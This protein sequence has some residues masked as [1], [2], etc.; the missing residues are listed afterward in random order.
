[1]RLRLL[2]LSCAAMTTTCA[3]AADFYL[4]NLGFSIDQGVS[5]TTKTDGPVTM[6][7][8]RA[9]VVAEVLHAKSLKYISDYLNTHQE[10]M[11]KAQ[12][13]STLTESA[14][15]KIFKHNSSTTK[16]TIIVSADAFDGEQFK[17]KYFLF[18]EDLDAGQSIG[19]NDTLN[20]E[21]NSPT[22][23]DNNVRFKFQAK[24]NNND[25]K[26]FVPI[27]LTPSHYLAMY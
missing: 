14:Y 19:L 16:L 11:T 23:Q 2:I 27:S 6:R 20:V 13:P 15:T 25:G 18:S 9:R 1:M 21:F 10:S 26:G 5:I 12:F 22:V 17:H 7:N 8:F 3:V 4:N 24:I